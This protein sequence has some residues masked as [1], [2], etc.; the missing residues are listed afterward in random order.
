MMEFF[1][2]S[3]THQAVVP[4]LPPQPTNAKCDHSV[5]AAPGF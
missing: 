3:P 5:E 2:F 4:S 1:D